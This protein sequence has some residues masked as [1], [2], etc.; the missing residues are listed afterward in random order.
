MAE[1][2]RLDDF[3]SYAVRQDPRWFVIVDL[4]GLRAHQVDEARRRIG[5]NPMKR[6]A[7]Q[8]LLAEF[9]VVPS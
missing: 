5:A 8:S 9:P 3:L 1:I 7:L 2:I 4:L 6:A